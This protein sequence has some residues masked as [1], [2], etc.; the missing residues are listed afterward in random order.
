MKFKKPTTSN[1][2]A[3]WLVVWVLFSL[4][5]PGQGFSDGIIVGNTIGVWVL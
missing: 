2:A 5:L 1:T 4:V 3:F